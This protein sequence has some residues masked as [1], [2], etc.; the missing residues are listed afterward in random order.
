MLLGRDAD[1]AAFWV[2]TLLALRSIATHTLAQMFS[3]RHSRLR[4]GPKCRDG[5]STLSH[6]GNRRQQQN[7]TSP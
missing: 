4:R 3:E 7:K 1:E 5:K 2:T 6:D